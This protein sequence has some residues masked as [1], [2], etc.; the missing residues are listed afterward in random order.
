MHK[1]QHYFSYSRRCLCACVKNLMPMAAASENQ[2]SFMR[3][4]KY[5]VAFANWK[6]GAYAELGGHKIVSEWEFLSIQ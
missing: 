6:G 3:G 2:V 1:E 4:K 5:R